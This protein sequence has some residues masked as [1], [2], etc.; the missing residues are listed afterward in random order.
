MLPL[1]L[2]ATLRY[3]GYFYT[4]S[5]AHGDYVAET[6]PFTNLVHISDVADPG[7]VDALA[8]KARAGGAKVVYRVME[9][10]FEPG[11][12]YKPR[13]NWQVR[14]NT[15]PLCAPAVERLAAS[16]DLFA[17][18]LA[19]EPYGNGLT[20]GDV[21]AAAAAVHARVP[22]AR[23]LVV[24]DANAADAS[25]P[26]AVDLYGLTCYTDAR[27]GD[28]FDR[29]DA[30]YRDLRRRFSGDIVVVAQAFA[31]L[32][33]P[34][35]DPQRWYELARSDPRYVALLWFL[36]PDFKH[37][38]ASHRGSR[39]DPPV[40]LAEQRIG[41][42]ILCNTG[43]APDTAKCVGMAGGGDRL[44]GDVNGDGLPDL[45]VRRQLGGDVDVFLSGGGTLDYTGAW[46]YGYSRSYDVLL[47]DV[48]GDGRDD[49]VARNRASGDVLVG[50]STGDAF[51]SPQRWTYGYGTSYRLALE[52]VDG[53]GRA[54]LVARIGE[55]TLLGSSSGRAFLSPTPLQRRS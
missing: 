44:E 4:A 28:L 30:T 43:A 7:R 19:D 51:A 37:N 5:D 48:D 8:R 31:V 12:P 1:L 40:L 15:D 39:S 6:T 55:R 47:G 32:G 10:F 27:G 11:R 34:I 41:R 18:Y 14:W 46:T 52:D 2:A 38:G 35:P 53:D 20:R 54:D 50:L 33:Q 26:P 13:A 24:E 29:C 16:G 21:D 25:P 49:L 17:V 22:S 36:Y 42:R 3:V 23:T 9:C 45:V